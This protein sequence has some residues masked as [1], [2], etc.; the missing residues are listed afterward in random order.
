MPFVVNETAQSESN[1]EADDVFPV[2]HFSESTCV[3]NVGNFFF[4]DFVPTLAARKC[5]QKFRRRG[6]VEPRAQPT[7]RLRLQRYGRASSSAGVDQLDRMDAFALA[8]I[9]EEK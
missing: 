1:C 2:H 9:Q 6:A 4:E 5:P 7:P 3:E 8:A